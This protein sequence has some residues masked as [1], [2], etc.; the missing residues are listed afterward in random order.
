MHLIDG[1][2]IAKKIEAEI[3]K[4]S[5]PSSLLPLAKGRKGGVGGLAAILIGTNPESRLYVALKEKAAKKVGIKFIKILYP[6]SPTPSNSPL[7]RGRTTHLENK[8]IKKIHQLNNDKTITGII[9]QLPL[10]KYL[11]TDKI[12]AAM[13]PKKDVDG[14]H[15]E[16]IAAYKNN[17]CPKM[18]A[19]VFTAVQ[20]ILKSIKI[21]TRG[22]NIVFVSKKNSIFPL[23]FE[24]CFGRDAKKFINCAPAS[25][26]KYLASADIII[27][28]VGKKHYLKSSM[29]K[30]GAII[31]DIGI[32]RIGHHVFGDADPVSLVKKRGWLT[33]VPGGV[34]PVTVACLLKNT[35]I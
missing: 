19:A 28:A 26:K 6:F 11:N 34:G 24:H 2:A 18:P 1:K 12:I 33:P 16:N 25:A 7:S 35:V 5:N 31:I 30:N 13:D 14:Y 21:K 15:P 20:E 3:K 22:K 32:D 29:V 9:V 4:R 27:T 8:I 17:Q 10:P 23:P